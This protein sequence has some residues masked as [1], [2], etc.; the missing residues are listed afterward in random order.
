[1]DEGESKLLL[2]EKLTRM[3]EIL[4]HKQNKYIRRNLGP[5]KKDRIAKDLETKKSLPIKLKQ[6]HV[7]FLLASGC[8]FEHSDLQTVPSPHVDKSAVHTE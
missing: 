8:D 5:G 7:C 4:W 3:T 1:M 2:Q 6:S